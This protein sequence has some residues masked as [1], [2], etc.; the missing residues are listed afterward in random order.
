MSHEFE[1]GFFVKKPAWHKLGIVLENAPTVEEGIRLA[2]LD[3]QVME[4]PV[5]SDVNYTFDHEEQDIVPRFTNDVPCNE[6]KALIRS[7]DATVLGVVKRT[8]TPLQNESAFSFF[9]PFLAEGDAELEAA[10]SLKNGKIVWV[11]ANLKNGDTQVLADDRVNNYL[12]LCN[13]HDGSMAVW[14]QF[15]AIRVVCWNTLSLALSLG[16]GDKE[17]MIKVQHRSNVDEGLR[18]VQRAVDLS[19]RSFH[20]TLD[21]YREMAKHKFS[22]SGFKKYVQ[23]VFVPPIELEDD[24]DKMPRCYEDLERLWREGTGTDIPGV[25]DTLWGA[26]NAITEWTTHE[27]GKSDETRLRSQWF[28]QSA[29]DTDKALTEARK[30]VGMASQ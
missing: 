26:Y 18:A 10:G 14:I 25:K 21:V 1:S 30:L 17:N 9:N 22:L 16:E 29:R 15:T 28:G 2:G 7:T 8:W 4:R 5:F 27:R 23:N 3:W 6:H 11:L 13:S 20:L 24:P 19:R 12:L